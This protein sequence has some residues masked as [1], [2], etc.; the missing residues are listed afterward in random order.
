M[1]FPRREGRRTRFGLVGLAAMTSAGALGHRRR[2]CSSS[3]DDL[4]V[5]WQCGQNWR[6]AASLIEVSLRPSRDG[7]QELR[8]CALALPLRQCNPGKSD[9][10]YLCGRVERATRRGCSL[11]S[12]VKPSALGGRSMKSVFAYACATWPSAN[13]IRLVHPN[14]PSKHRLHHILHRGYISAA[15]LSKARTICSAFRLASRIEKD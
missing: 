1:C 4:T 9:Y 12:D 5:T 7:V 13:S 15:G 6:E 3:L 2:M 14:P 11:S 10:C 8:Q